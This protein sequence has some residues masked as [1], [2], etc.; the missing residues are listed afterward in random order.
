MPLCLHSAKSALCCCKIYPV[1]HSGYAQ[2][3]VW[4]WMHIQRVCELHRNVHDWLKTILL[5]I[6]NEELQK[7]VE[8]CLR[9]SSAYMQLHTFNSW[10]LFLKVEMPA[11]AAEW[12]REEEKDTPF[13]KRKTTDSSYK[14]ICFYFP[15][16]ET[17]ILFY[18]GFFPT[19]CIK[20]T[21][22]LLILTRPFTKR[23]KKIV[24]ILV[25]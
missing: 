25:F 7:V 6:C 11:E 17:N 2:K 10:Q 13:Y 8:R 24:S 16:P 1:L 14:P 9:A 3:K 21:Q 19:I 5:I 22:A 18:F 4:R 20:S 23:C 12:S 15:S